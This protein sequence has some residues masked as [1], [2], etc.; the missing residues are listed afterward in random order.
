MNTVESKSKIVVAVERALF[1]TSE[2][3]DQLSFDHEKAIPKISSADLSAIAE[4]IKRYC[5]DV[6]TLEFAY[7]NASLSRNAA[8]NGEASLLRIV[9]NAD[10]DKG[11]IARFKPG[12]LWQAFS[13]L[14]EDGHISQF[15]E[16]GQVTP[17]SIDGNC[18]GILVVRDRKYHNHSQPQFAI[19][20]DVILDDCD[21]GWAA[22]LM[23]DSLLNVQQKQQ[24]PA[25]DIERVAVLNDDL[26][27]SQP[28]NQEIAQGTESTGRR[29]YMDEI[30]FADYFDREGFVG[31]D[32]P[33]LIYLAKYARFMASI[34]IKKAFESQ[35]LENKYRV[36]MEDVTTLHNSVRLI[37][38]DTEKKC[39]L[40]DSRIGLEA[41]C[42]KL[43]GEVVEALREA[44]K[45][46]C[47]ARK[48]KVFR[49][50]DVQDEISQSIAIDFLAEK[51]MARE[52]LEVLSEMK[53][54]FSL[55][56]YKHPSGA[57]FFTVDA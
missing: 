34:F 52:V 19:I 37:I 7:A 30:R 16:Q 31:G 22:D 2:G 56:L 28:V 13:I 36:D 46:F 15:Y 26:E 49:E 11:E 18:F 53:S 55:Q 57:K 29:N 50:S 3:I 5:G 33:L 24:Q 47:E 44:E 1:A 17:I 48:A 21:R 6:P 41:N 39:D 27:S 42:E 20:M 40:T 32:S 45:N 38:V 35:N 54:M 12:L 8:N 14:A 10:L 43:P 25:V 4:L 23:V 9:C 51:N